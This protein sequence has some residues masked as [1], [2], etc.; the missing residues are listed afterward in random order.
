MSAGGGSGKPPESAAIAPPSREPLPPPTGVDPL[1]GPF[2]T[3]A[4]AP[5]IF[6]RV[7]GI[8]QIDVVVQSHPQGFR[9]LRA[10]RGRIVADPRREPTSEAMAKG[11]LIPF[12]P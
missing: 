6:W 7:L 10:V 5:A 11:V 3:S 12:A 4:M 8:A 2:S 9:N 1:P